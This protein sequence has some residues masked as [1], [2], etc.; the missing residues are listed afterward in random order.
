MCLPD[1]SDCGR[2]DQCCS[3]ICDVRICRTCTS[4]GQPC[5]AN[6]PPCCRSSLGAICANGTCCIPAGIGCFTNA[7]CCAG[8]SCIASTCS[9]F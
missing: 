2:D 7:D 6:T 1:G 4:L 3:G 8:L 9:G 5:N